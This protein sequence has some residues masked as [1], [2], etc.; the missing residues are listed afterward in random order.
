MRK[1]CCRDFAR[2][3]E[4]QTRG[5]VAESETGL[6]SLQLDCRGERCWR[7]LHH[8]PGDSSAVMAA[9][10]AP[11]PPGTA[12][13]SFLT[14]TME[15]HTRSRVDTHAKHRDSILPSRYLDTH[16]S[17]CTLVCLSVGKVTQTMACWVQPLHRGLPSTVKTRSGREICILSKLKCCSC[18]CCPASVHQSPSGGK[19]GI[20]ATLYVCVSSVCHVIPSLRTIMGKHC[21]C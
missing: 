8:S 18:P 9:G 11:I 1:V 14:L 6:L 5:K 15:T 4:R 19:H 7:K 3:R 17:S 21:I 2:A 20:V 12:V 10:V 16:T 13:L